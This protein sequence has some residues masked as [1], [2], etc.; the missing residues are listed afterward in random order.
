MSYFNVGDYVE[1]VDPDHFLFGSKGI[2]VKKSKEF[3]RQYTPDTGK[4]AVAV[5][6]S[7][8]KEGW[9]M[10][11]KKAKTHTI[12]GSINSNTGFSMMPHE[13]RHA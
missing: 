7:I 8:K 10:F 6:F 4:K 1:V 12:F 3:L 11:G 13:I 9:H 5:D 2:V